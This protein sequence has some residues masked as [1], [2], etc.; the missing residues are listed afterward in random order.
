[1]GE[2]EGGIVKLEELREIASKRTKGEWKVTQA[3][4]LNNDL[5]TGFVDPAFTPFGNGYSS[6]EDAEFIALAANTYDQ[7]LKVAECANKAAEEIDKYYLKMSQSSHVQTIAEDD[8]DLWFHRD[9]IMMALKEL[10][11]SS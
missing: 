11:G 1:M 6:I 4:G 7:L 9:N 5:S 2:G 8:H 10:E 3:Y